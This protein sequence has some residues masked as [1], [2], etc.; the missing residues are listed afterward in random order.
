MGS[1]G[2]KV[3]GSEYAHPLISERA[4]DEPR[5]L[6]VIYI[7]A[8]VSGI[9]AAIQFP[10]AIPNLELAV[11]EKNADLSFESNLEWSK[12]YAG[13]PEILEYWRKVVEKYKIRK[14]MKF[15]HRCIEARWNEETS[16]WHVKFQKVG[17][18]EIVEDISDVF[19]TGTGVLNEWKWPDIKG[20]QDF[21]GTLMHSAD[22]DPSYDA[23]DKNIAVIGAGSSG[24]QIVPTLQPKVKSMDC[25]I[26]GRTWIAATFGNELVR[27]RN[28]GQDGNFDYTQEEIEAW[29]KDP[30]SYIKYRKALEI[31]MQGNFAMTHRGT[32]E[33]EGATAQFKED[34]G[35]RLA[36]K[37][38]IADHLIPD[39]PP[40]CKRLTPGPGYLEA[41]TADNVNVVYDKISHVDETGI[42]T[43]DGKHRPVDTIVCA[44]GFDTSFQG[45]FPIY[46]R[47]GINLQERYRVRPETYLT[48]SVDQFPNFFQSL[49]P[50]AGVGNGN[51]LIIAEAVA[52]YVVQILQRLAQGNV[53][54]I[55]PKKKQVENFTNYCDA[56][57]KRT[58]FSAECGSWYKSAP[59]NATREERMKGRVTALWPGS[60]I[61]AVRALE[62]VRFDDFEMTTVDGND[63]GW[64]GDGWAVAE[65]SGDV[66]GLSW[67]LNGT[68]FV[69]EP[70]EKGE[71]LVV[72]EDKVVKHTDEG[73]EK[74]EIAKE[75]RIPDGVA[76]T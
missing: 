42:T 41:L 37:Q 5:P 26:R 33:H 45:R 15:S 30:A 59:P 51:L 76:A 8:G 9:C 19:M 34:M 49:G 10:K 70:L 62:H 32:K 53:K 29:K 7:G 40:L 52:L 20:L 25:Y 38:E 3:T 11:Y 35:K 43:T 36:K 17:S 18:N 14:Y 31:G 61:H 60:S 63:F 47:G 1:L 46:G 56:Y 12:F 23:T 44:T 66:E 75:F 73:V 72:T 21:K 67:Y 57:F 27:E 28:D 68:R 69:H 48:V 39:F 2:Y 13:S 58:V 64:F 22:W 50:N 24:I 16:K 71:K 65:R 4:I 74:G 6:K 55:E 54:T